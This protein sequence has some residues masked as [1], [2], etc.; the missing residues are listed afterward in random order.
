MEEHTKML[1]FIG[2]IDYDVLKENGWVLTLD[3]NPR[4]TE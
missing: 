3:S 2:L 1:M 4:V